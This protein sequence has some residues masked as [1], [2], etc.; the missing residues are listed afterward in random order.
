M[1]LLQLLVALKVRYP[2]RITILRGNHESRQVQLNIDFLMLTACC[3]LSTVTRILS[4]IRE[5]SLVIDMWMLFSC[6][7]FALLQFRCH[8]HCFVY[9]LDATPINIQFFC[10]FWFKLKLVFYDGCRSHRCMDFTT[11]AYESE[12]IRCLK[13]NLH[14]QAWHVPT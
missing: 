1:F 7:E 10:V 4:E 14:F 6:S 8:P 3:F 12:F 2:H 13:L 11:N 5:N 9:N